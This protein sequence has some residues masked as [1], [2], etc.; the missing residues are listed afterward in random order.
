MH[1]D[2]DLL[3]LGFGLL[4]QLQL[5]HACIVAGPHVLSVHSGGQREGAVEAAVAPLDAM[6]V[7]FLLFFLEL[8]LAAYGKR[9]VLDP[10][11]QILF[12]DAGDVQLSTTFSLFS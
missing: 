12:L 7:L 6:E 5:E 2:L 1:V 3:G 10:N 11:V 4:L 9:L 8:A